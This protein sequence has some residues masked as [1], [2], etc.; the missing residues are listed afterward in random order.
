MAPKIDWAQYKKNVPVA[1]M[2]DNFQ[3]H[4]EAL[5]VPYPVDN[6]SAQVDQQ[7]AQVTKEIEDFKNAS[8]QRIAAHEKD[9]AHLKSLLPYGQMTME[10]FA[11][12][13]PDQALDAI[14]KPTFWPH[15]KAE[16]EPRVVSDE[17]H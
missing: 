4:Y 16:Q 13:F 17:H 7:K 12:S 5:T 8:K 2:V 15:D 1:G 14:N 3:K 11:D 6:F 9:L 10:D